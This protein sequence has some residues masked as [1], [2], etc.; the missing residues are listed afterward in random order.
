MNGDDDVFEWKRNVPEN[1][2]RQFALLDSY[3]TGIEKA[4]RTASSRSEAEIVVASACGRFER[5]CA[6]G[7]LRGAVTKHIRGLLSLYWGAGA[8]HGYY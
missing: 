5:E 3:C 8:E 1:I 7:I 6:S 4:I 2:G